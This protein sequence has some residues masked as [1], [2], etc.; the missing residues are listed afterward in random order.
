MEELN[1]GPSNTDPS[2]SRVEDLNSGP[3]DY[4]S[5]D[6]PLGH[7]ASITTVIL[8]LISVWNKCSFATLIKFCKHDPSTVIIV[9]KGTKFRKEATRSRVAIELSLLSKYPVVNC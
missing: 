9:S 2:G 1:L 5:S 3:L 7:A 4:K 8:S 6:L